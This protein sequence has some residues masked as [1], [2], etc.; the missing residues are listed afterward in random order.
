MAQWLEKP[1]QEPRPAT[2]FRL[3]FKNNKLKVFNQTEYLWA[4]YWSSCDHHSLGSLS[5]L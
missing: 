2:K 4:P 5:F 3:A 1:N